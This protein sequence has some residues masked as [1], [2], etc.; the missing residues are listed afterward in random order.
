MCALCTY[1]LFLIV[2]VCACACVCVC[3]CACVCV[4][5]REWVSVCVCGAMTSVLG[6]ICNQ[7]I[8]RPS[9][10]CQLTSQIHYPG[11]QHDGWE[12]EVDAQ[13]LSR[14]EALDSFHDQRF[15]V[16]G[17]FGG[18]I[19]QEGCIVKKVYIVNR[20]T[21]DIFKVVHAPKIIQLTICT[22][23][24]SFLTAK[25]QLFPGFFEIFL[26]YFSFQ[27]LNMIAMP[28]SHLVLHK[29]T[30]KQHFEK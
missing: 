10:C 1:V 23:T 16:L 21:N 14:S 8:F 11:H 27:D 24:H 12:L 6:L 20:Y 15:L 4:R 30:L 25:K 17:C 9:F 2:C 28:N 5:A 18:S 22:L 7:I 29:E 13:S 19:F 26:C 3:V